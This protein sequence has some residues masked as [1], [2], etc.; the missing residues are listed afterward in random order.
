MNSIVDEKKDVA[1][2]VRIWLFAFKRDGVLG[3]H[4][5]PVKACPRKIEYKL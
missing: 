3:F 1:M 5:I 2:D 4:M